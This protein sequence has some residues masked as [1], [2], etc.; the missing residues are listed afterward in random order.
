M[1]RFNQNQRRRLGNTARAVALLGLCTAGCASAG[2]IHDG[3]LQSTAPATP[4]F[5]DPE[6]L[7]PA[8][9]SP[10]SIIGYPVG[11]TAVRYD[12]LTR[13]LHT[14]ADASPLVTITPYAQ[15]HEGRTLYYLTITSRE[16]H[17]KIDQIRRDNAK[18]A[19]PR[20]LAADDDAQSIIKHLP[21]IAW[22]AYGIHGD[23]L[24]STDAA[25]QLAYQLAAGT[26]PAT[27]AL[28]EQ[29]VIHIDPTMN[30]DGRERYLT[31]LQQ[32][33]G[34]V[35]NTD[36]QSMQHSGLWSAGRGNHYL[37]DL[38]RDWLM[39]VHPETRGRAAAI[40]SW[41]PH[42]LVDSHEMGGL[43]TYLFDP[44]REPIS[45]YL[46][47]K[48]L[49]WRRRFSAD[50]AAAFD[51][52]GWS[53][54][55]REW[56]E[57]WYPGY[58]NGWASLLGAVGVL[59]EQARVNGAAI[60]QATGQSLTYREAVYHHLTSSLANL[61]S[62]RAHRADIIAAFHADR[63]WAVSDEGPHTETLLVSPTPDAPAMAR[64]VDLLR[65]QGIES[66]QA[67][68]AFQTRGVADQWGNRQESRQFPAGTLIVRSNQPHR[69]LLHA[70]LAFDPHTS[71]T[72]LNEERK[73]LENHRSTRVYD[74]TA[75]NLTMAF[76]LEA[77]WANHANV[78]AS[79]PSTDAPSIDASNS[80]AP[81][82]AYGWIIDGA[83]DDIY[84]AIIRLFDDKL[85]LRVATKP[86]TIGG[87]D[88]PPGSILLRRHENPSTAATAL[89]EIQAAFDLR[90]RSVD[91][92]L[93]EQGPDLGGQR[94]RL[95]RQPRVAIASQWPIATTSFGSVWYLLDY[96]L[97]LRCSPLN[98]QNLAT[99]DLRKYNVLILPPSWSENR[100]E[101]VLGERGVDKI[102]TWVRAGGTLIAIGNSASFFANKKRDM[103]S[104]RRR[105]DV[106]KELPV[107][108]EA[109]K[110]E[111]HARNVNVDPDQVWGRSA[112]ESESAK[113]QANA[114]GGDDDKNDKKTQDA[115]S[116]ERSDQ[117][118]RLFSP[119]G[120]IVA[121][122][123]NPEHWLCFGA[124]EK[125][126][127][128]ISGTVA[129]LSKPP[130]AT[131]VRLL[132]V[133]HLRLSG[134]LW[135]E[136]RQR[137]ANSAYATVESVG[138]GQLVLFAAEPFFRGFFEG[139]G[140][141]LLN[142]VVL[143]PGLGASAP[144]PW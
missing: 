104:V 103:S 118:Q 62:L 137:L 15:S 85:Q 141:L 135:P 4:A 79:T 119:R 1:L 19:D 121:A 56:Y 24:S 131:P 97:G 102:R 73:D 20:T 10:E 129:Y 42:L 18:L 75:W 44:P 14:L 101:A 95:L 112:T 3:P 124:G 30:P 65:R 120:A 49:D 21:G 105:R 45:V 13:Y 28:R 142:A 12:P 38:N 11:T 76:G 37:F 23:E 133:D 69:R 2:P 81:E 96:R 59:Y 7:N 140:R 36:N 92:A 72:F 116:L 53:Y 110:R 34:R 86:F 132:D 84:A 67:T 87:H 134:L 61:E 127:V 5:V 27:T 66:S 32:L 117:W 25:M 78:V 88:Y 52:H 114:D 90:I 77:F 94:F 144:L 71:D 41:N 9:P 122:A 29:L 111:Q 128:L 83:T 100:V 74:I 91:T 50:Q 48:V 64:L 98:I 68:E 109:L 6:T 8:I 82:P 43:D 99:M 54:Y 113:S 55:T 130:A 138:N 60:T 70:I 80:V 136:A 58:T 39:Q 115:K 17:A 123:L 40:L 22:L 93:A 106:L 63:V 139:T 126:P 108:A 35:V 46:S 143:G 47:K 57:E 107:Y 31:Q 33:T 26:D 125:L 89:T 51:R 16:N